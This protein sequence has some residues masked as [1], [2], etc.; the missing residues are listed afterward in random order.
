MKRKS[1]VIFA[2]LVALASTGILFSCG[3]NSAMEQSLPPPS[4]HYTIGPEDVIRID[5]WKEP[6]LSVSVP[7]RSDGK[8][9]LPLIH[10]V[11][12]IGLTPLELREELTRKL[13][14]YLENP[15]VAVIIEQI[16][17]L[18]IFVTGEVN[19]PGVFELESEANL[20][21]AISMAGGFTE[22]AN[23][24]KI[25]VFRKHRDI[26]TI[27]TINYH[28]IISGKQPDLNIPLQPGDTIVVP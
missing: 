20:L 1:T 12:V 27:I 18:K 15:N 22:W 3:G 4:A 25:K 11:Y 7:V 5:V 19:E 28:K 10:D 8:I 21:Q 2:L 23:R 24:K 26:E 16:N 14:Q 13:T 17:S 9:S 6:E